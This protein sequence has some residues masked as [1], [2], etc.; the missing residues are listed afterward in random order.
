VR[1]IEM[2]SPRHGAS[3]HA[4]SLAQVGR[5][6]KVSRPEMQTPARRPAE[7]GTTTR[8]IIEAQ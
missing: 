1:G 6:M 4:A 7:C 3:G 2:N 5:K 8:R